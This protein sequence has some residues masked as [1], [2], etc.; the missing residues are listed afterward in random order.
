M[1]FEDICLG[2][3][4]FSNFGSDLIFD[5]WSTYDGRSLG[6]IHCKDVQKFKFKNELNG[7]DLFGSYIA[8]LKI[9]SGTLIMESGEIWIKVVCS[10]I[11][12]T[13]AYS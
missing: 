2:T 12:S 5:I 13:I 6:K 4:E 3:I 7:E 9:Q 11:I 10:E 1:T 8:L